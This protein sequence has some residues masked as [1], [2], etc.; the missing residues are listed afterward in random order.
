MNLRAMNPPSF[1]LS[2]LRDHRRRLLLA[3]SFLL[4]LVLPA[5][6]PG[7]AITWVNP[8]AGSFGDFTNWDPSQVPGPMDI[9]L[10]ANGGT[11]NLNEF[12]G[13][14]SVS[15]LFVGR[16]ANASGTLNIS[17]GILSLE[18]APGV[19]TS[20]QAGIGNNAVGRITVELDGVL[21]RGVGWLLIGGGGGSGYLAISNQGTV[22]LNQFR[23]GSDNSAT[24]PPGTGY[25]DIYD[26]TVLVTNQVII[27]RDF[28][29]GIVNVHTNG[30][31][32]N[33]ATAFFN[34]SDSDAYL[35]IAGSGVNAGGT[36]VVSVAAG[37]MLE[38]A[39]GIRI[40]SAAAGAVAKGTLR[41]NGGTLVV[42]RIFQGNTGGS[43]IGLVELNGGTIRAATATNPNGFIYGDLTLRLGSAGIVI[44]AVGF[45]LP[46]HPAL[47][48]DS[49]SPGGGVTKIGE[50]TLSL[51]GTNTYTGATVIEGGKVLL[52]SG[53][54][55]GGAVT[56]NDGAGFAVRLSSAGSS[57]NVSTLTLNTGAGSRDLDFDLSLFGNPTAPVVNATTLAANRTS[58]INVRGAGF[59]VGEFTLIRFGSAPGLEPSHFMLGSLPPGVSAELVL[60]VDSV[61]LRI[62]AAPALHWAGTLSS[63]WDTTTFNWFDVSTD[64]AASVTYTDDS[65]VFF[66]DDASTGSVNLALVVRPAAITV[67]NAAVAYTFSGFGS[68][69]G[70]AS[71]RKQ[72]PGSLTVTSP[73]DY[74]GDTIISGG[75]LFLGASG[76]IPQGASRGDVL[77]DGTLDLSGFNDGI[78][79]LSGSGVIDNSSLTTSTHVR[80]RQR[81][82]PFFRHAQQHRRGRDQPH[83]DEWRHRRVQWRS[84]SYWRCH[85]FR[86]YSH[87]WRR[88]FLR[89]RHHHLQRHA[90]GRQ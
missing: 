2:G 39:G 63:D 29:T 79:G 38:A 10:I 72:G 85:R 6:V 18:G 83:Q 87:L 30:V 71:F 74:F 15:N 34:G 25:L 82:R 86:R 14:Y 12:G 3:C 49:S 7:A 26:G 66:G 8:G 46:I 11:A 9:G 24:T 57:L 35:T 61:N 32:V 42:Q 16:G 20:P 64:P 56:A 89:R 84:Y 80:Q 50:G 60:T 22:H 36:G 37:G 53:S 88:Q 55:G 23:A 28:D 78:N 44:D 19:G 70:S 77:V 52:T 48:A 5:T 17:A 68:I 33:Y 47:L 59:S 65:A 58:I 75:T 41:L 73:N 43:S 27:G 76:V 21:E 62:T 4:S 31:F 51:L 54:S 1:N 81:I 69:A 67:S 45:D 13:F 40:A 90:P